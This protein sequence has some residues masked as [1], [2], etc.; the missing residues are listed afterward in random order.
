MAI[1]LETF[2]RTS[3]VFEREIVNENVTGRGIDDFL[4]PNVNADADSDNFAIDSLIKTV[5]GISFRKKDEQSVLRPFENGTG[6]VYEVPLASEK[7]PISERLRGAVIAGQEVFASLSQREQA[8]YKETIAFHTVAYAQTRWKLALDTVRTGVFSPMGINGNDIGLSIDF[9]RDASL[10]LSYNFTATGAT[11]DAALSQLLEA[12]YAQNGY[13]DDLYLIAGRKWLAEFYKDTGVKAKME[14][15]LSNVL[16]TSG[17][18]PV[19]LDGVYGL[20]VQ[21]NYLVDGQTNPLAI[22]S[23]RP[24]GL[25][26]AYKGA[27]PEAFVPDEEAILI[28]TGSTRYKVL[29]GVDVFNDAKQP[30]RAVGDVVF[31]T[32]TEDDPIR[33]FLRSHARFAFVPGNINHTAR[34][35][36]TFDGDSE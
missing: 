20:K 3:K 13:G 22:C 18:S 24:Q 6:M 17:L 5:H 14:K 31:D 10:S 36:G 11:F 7:T 32:Y 29:R 35:R 12:Y 27:T 15:N 1:A 30:V 19:G 33:T 21:A 8:I 28:S 23:Y 16:V 9:G 2:T 25:F 26:A 4:F 34:I